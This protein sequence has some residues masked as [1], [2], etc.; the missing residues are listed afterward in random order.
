M[1]KINL[2]KKSAILLKKHSGRTI[3]YILNTSVSRNKDT[4][5]DEMILVII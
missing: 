2:L 4:S 3:I 1:R 5:Q